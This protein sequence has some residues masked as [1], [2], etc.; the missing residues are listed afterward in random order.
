MHQ[1]FV[2]ST[3]SQ[4]FPYNSSSLEHHVKTYLKY[5]LCCVGELPMVSKG[6]HVIIP[7][8]DGL[9]D[10]RWEAKI[11]EQ[12]GN[13]IKLSVNSPASAVCGLY[14]LTVTCSS[15]KGEATTYNSSKNVVMLFNPWCEGKI[16]SMWTRLRVYTGWGQECG[17]K[18]GERWG[19]N[20]KK[21]KV[22][23]EQT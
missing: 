18:E 15:S 19:R 23:V 21:R 17:R 10:E 8:V 20:D 14:G 13:K 1:A 6:T 12:N 7:L 22:M 3:P 2:M 9:E 16:G 11:V 4:G 5:N